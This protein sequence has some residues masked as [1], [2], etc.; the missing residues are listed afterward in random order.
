MLPATTKPVVN[1]FLSKTKLQ[2]NTPNSA[3]MLCHHH[4]E[5]LS[6]WI[7][8]CLPLHLVLIET[9][10]CI[11]VVSKVIEPL[12]V[13]GRCHGRP[14][15]TNQHRQLCAGACVTE[16]C[17][18][19]VAKGGVALAPQVGTQEGCSCDGGRVHVWADDRSLQRGREGTEGKGKGEA[20]MEDARAERES[21]RAD[22]M[23][24]VSHMFMKW[25]RTHCYG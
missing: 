7:W 11:E 5:R 1:L 24:F 14:C 21:S 19:Q 4:R 16:A 20:V 23:L 3:S 12:H 22:R 8:I 17:A 2:L 15:F 13:S 6:V 25:A 9:H 10:L 18:L